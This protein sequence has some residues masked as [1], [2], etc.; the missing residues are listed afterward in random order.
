MI[1]LSEMAQSRNFFASGLIFFF[2]QGVRLD[3][4]AAA[5]NGKTI[6]TSAPFFFWFTP[7]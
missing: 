7:A 3:V 5:L 2:D 1:A 4:P 6:S